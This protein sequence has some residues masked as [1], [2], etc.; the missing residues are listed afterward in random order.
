MTRPQWLTVLAFVVLYKLGDAVIGNLFNPFLLATGFSKTQIAE[1]VKLYGLAA[2]LLGSFAGGWCVMRFGT[3]RTLLVGGI[4]HSAINLLLILQAQR[5][6]DVP[7]LAFTTV[8][9]NFTGA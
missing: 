2:T 3:F 9:I 6:V 4:V 5:G 7:F 1:I 8:A